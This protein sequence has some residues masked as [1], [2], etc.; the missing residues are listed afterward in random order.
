MKVMLH[1]QCV[2]CDSDDVLCRASMKAVLHRPCVSV[3]A[4]MMY[5]VEHSMKAVLPRECVCCDSDD[6]LC[7]TQYEGGATPVLH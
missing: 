4:V 6:V 1:R 2:C 5:C 3:V 7:G